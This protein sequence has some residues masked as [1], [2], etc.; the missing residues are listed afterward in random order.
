MAA[1]T[2][3][4]ALALAAFYGAIYLLASALLG[5]SYETIPEG[6]RTLAPEE[7]ERVR[8]AV[9]ALA[10]LMG[11]WAS[12]LGFVAVNFAGRIVPPQIL[13]VWRTTHLTILLVLALTLGVTV[14]ARDFIVVLYLIFVIPG[15]LLLR[16]LVAI[17]FAIGLKGKTPLGGFGQVFHVLIDVA[18]VTVFFIVTLYAVGY[19]FAGP[20]DPI[21]DVSIC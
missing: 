1:R 12:A 9:A 20:M 21:S 10:I 6:C 13:P 11:G 4:A 19:L 8:P 18:W 16:L 15:A 2:A 14:Y 5:E 7:V 3:L 17:P